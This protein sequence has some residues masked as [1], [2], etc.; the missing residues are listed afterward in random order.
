MNIEQV[1]A[2]A[3]KRLLDQG[4]DSAQVSVG[5]SQQDEL[6]IAIS[7]ASLFRST[8]DHSLSLKGI[9]DGRVA[10]AA[11]TDLSEDSVTHEV[12]GLFERA[13][14]APQDD[15]NAVS[16]DQSLHVEKGPQEGD[17]TLMVDKVKELL[18]FR[19]QE[20]PKMSIDEGAAAFQKSED[21][22]LTSG[23]S[24][25]TSSVGCYGLSAFG[26][27]TD[28]DK[29]SSFNY[30][31]GSTDDLGTVHAADHFGI[32]DMLK[33]TE[34]QIDT[35]SFDGNFVGDVVLAPTAVT[36]LLGW[37][38]SQLSDGQLIADSS[39]FRDKVGEVIASPLLTVKSRFDGPG[40]VGITGDG[41]VADDF[42]VVE[43]GRLTTLMPS[44]YGSLKTGIAHRP[45]S[46]GW[47][48]S[49]GTSSKSE[50]LGGL[51]KGAL[52]TRL[53]MGHPGP[54]GDFS[55][56]IKNSFMI[57]G[58]EIGAALSETMIA[59]NMAQ[60]LKDIVGISE[61]RMDDGSENLPWIRIANINYS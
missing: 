9:V 42:T 20:A 22:V 34:Q 2:G 60:M 13:K 29:S 24:K 4:F 53:S 23:G 33:D 27:A 58:G 35:H 39:V 30:A 44:L 51:Q 8:E 31:G 61:R 18:E 55:G 28:G 17:L 41:F 50:M 47:E 16:S 19:A 10:S 32:G 52:V 14:H 3:L 15:A 48:I 36:D 7:D 59:G 37:L 54:S 46:G 21:I 26:T 6:N 1:G 57:N 40:L 11:L 45:S 49:S 56:V 25:L 12:V 38:L 5:V 43:E